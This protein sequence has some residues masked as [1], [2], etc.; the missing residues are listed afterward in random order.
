MVGIARDDT[1][2]SARAPRE[3]PAARRL[4]VSPPS[5]LPRRLACH[6]AVIGADED[7]G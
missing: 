1:V 5:R 6:T 2:A 7:H 3:I 4:Y